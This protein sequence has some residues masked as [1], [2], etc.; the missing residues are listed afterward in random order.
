MREAGLTG[1]GVMVV[2]VSELGEE[3]TTARSAFIM[4][5]ME[6]GLRLIIRAAE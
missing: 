1:G 5:M 4:S 2:S 3:R 6:M